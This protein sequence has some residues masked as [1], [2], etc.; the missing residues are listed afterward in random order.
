MQYNSYTDALNTLVRV[1]IKLQ[2]FEIRTRKKSV[3]TTGNRYKRIQQRYEKTD[4][5]SIASC[6]CWLRYRILNSPELLIPSVG[7]V[8]DCNIRVIIIPS[9]L[10]FASLGR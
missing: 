8:W 2:R 6:T 3:R 4:N 7:S 5:T 10:A 9:I 1:V